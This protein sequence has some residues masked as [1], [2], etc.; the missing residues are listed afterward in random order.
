MPLCRPVLA[1]LSL[2]LSSAPSATLAPTQS[3]FLA[4]EAA[5]VALEAGQRGR[6]LDDVRSV[7]AEQYV[8]PELAQKMSDELA[9][10]KAAG[11][12]EALSSARAFARQLT[13]DLQSICHDK[14]LRVRF[15][16]E[17]PREGE[18]GPGPAARE[19]FLSSNCGFEK[20][21]RLAGNVGYLDLRS[22]A[23]LEFAAELATSSMTLLASSDALIIDLRRNGGGS[24]EMV[25]FLCSY[26]FEG[27]DVHLNDLYFRPRDQTR[28]FWTLGWVP[29]K[30]YLDKP[31]YVLT[32][33]K[34]FSGAEEFAYDL[35]CQERATL[36][37]ETTGGGANPGGP[38]RI[39]A[40]FEVFVPM[41][42]AINPRTKTNWEGTGVVPE[43]ACKAEEALTRAHQLA[44][45]TLIEKASGARKAALEEALAGLK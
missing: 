36:V 34:T 38:Q 9:R 40:G 31:V 13:E 39:A 5:D 15:V 12:Y 11:T 6:V 18:R 45:R 23:P 21:E 35:Q 2:W 44:L 24:P 16:G 29:G 37:G 27:D 7:L 33:S 17:S 4:A 8:F 20:L 10:R 30:R 42:R 41:G 32:S 22:F 1:L 14:H 28:Q 26:F 19:R 3:P 25:Q 43:V